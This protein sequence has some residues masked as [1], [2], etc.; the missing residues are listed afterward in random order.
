MA[1]YPEY[2]QLNEIIK[3]YAVKTLDSFKYSIYY[4]PFCVVSY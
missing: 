1:K 2:S 3:K 4:W